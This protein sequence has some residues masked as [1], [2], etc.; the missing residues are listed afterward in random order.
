MFGCLLEGNSFRYVLEEVIWFLNPAVA[1][2]T[3]SKNQKV[4][5]FGVL[6]FFLIPRSISSAQRNVGSP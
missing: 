4:L 1:T 3:S 6:F 2:H 5:E